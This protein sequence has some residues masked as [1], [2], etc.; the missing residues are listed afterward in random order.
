MDPRQYLGG[1]QLFYL[2][3]WGVFP[4]GKYKMSPEGTIQNKPL[5]KERRKEERRKIFRRSEDWVQEQ[6]QQRKAHKLHSLLELGQLIGLDLQLNEMLLQISQKACEVMEADRCS[7]FLH[8]T[9]TDELWS[10]VALG[11]AGEVIRIPSGIGLAGHCFQTGETINL[12]DAYTDRRF[13]KEVDSHT[14]YRTRSVLCMTF[15]NRE[16]SRLGVIQLLNK[17]DGVFT[18][19]DEAFLQTFGNNASVFIEMA[20]LQK[21]RIDAL[22]QSRKELEQLSR[23]KS[24]ALDH[25]SHELRTPLS[26]IQG[27]LRLLKRKLEMQTS[28]VEGEKFFETLERHL[29]RLFEI[30]KETDK[31]VQSNHQL[32][33]SGGLD[34][35]DRIWRKLEGISEI[36][37]DIKIHWEAI[38]KWM[39]K[40]VCHEFTSVEPVP[41]CP[42]TTKTLEQVKVHAAHRD[43]H[44]LLE[45]M[46]DLYA[47][48]DPRI[49]EDMLEGLLK[50][51]VENTPDEG[52]IR[53]LLEKQD[54]RPLLKVQDFGIGIT[55]ENQRYIFDGLF[56]TQ[57][58]ELY[59]S[60][61]PYDFG[62]GGKGLDLLRM[63]VYGHRFGFDITIGSKRCTY[64]PTDRDLCPGRIS[65]CPHCKKPEDCLSSG[66]STF[67]IS[68][69]I[70]KRKFSERVS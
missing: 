39:T 20:Q 13:N 29:N 2:T 1:R 54:Q 56:H 68:F 52:V 40:D 38:R 21:A 65:A 18:N 58:T 6:A 50:N 7:I 4:I 33:G 41:L 25:L 34:E 44:F 49:L 23:V 31:I 12:E 19:E 48:V 16:G 27:N 57:E 70:G 37:P 69:P 67:S 55:E 64:L 28:S 3:D 30:Q 42:I 60:K 15:Y 26:V 43:L 63:K 10:T 45:N 59:T 46:E 17:K 61:K 11:M 51:A 9:N 22:E 24:K 36:P 8:D 35:L 5:N 32:E 53:I 66:G 47:P 14:G 62:A